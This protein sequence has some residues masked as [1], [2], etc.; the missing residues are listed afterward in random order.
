MVPGAHNSGSTKMANAF[1]AFLSYLSQVRGK[2]W[3]P[4]N[5]N[6]KTR[7]GRAVIPLEPPGGGTNGILS[8]APSHW[9][10]GTHQ[11][12]QLGGFCNNRNP[13]RR[14]TTPGIK[15]EQG[16]LLVSRKSTWV[17]PLNMPLFHRK[18]SFPHGTHL[19]GLYHS[20]NI[21]ESH[22]WN[23][24]RMSAN[25][26]MTSDHGETLHGI[27]V[28]F[29]ISPHYC[30]G[31]NNH[32]THHLSARVWSSDS[33]SHS[34]SSDCSKYSSAHLAGDTDKGSLQKR[35]I[36]RGKKALKRYCWVPKAW[37]EMS[38]YTSPGNTN[39]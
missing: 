39:S 14:F 7:T 26:S 29:K 12:Q 37:G 13:H 8:W 2:G 23:Y 36:E 31:S 11:Y 34:F 4:L 5:A 6:K 1:R 16:T 9:E 24:R 30:G 38:H 18:R 20:P 15:S 28:T 27:T 32:G 25:F 21:P 17:L 3:L 33:P 35:R 22:S 19:S 10:L